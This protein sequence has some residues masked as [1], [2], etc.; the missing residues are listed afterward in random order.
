MRRRLALLL[1]LFA[2][3]CGGGGTFT[4]VSQPPAGAVAGSAWSYRLQ[5]QNAAGA[6]SYALL[7]GPD[8]MEL[9]AAGVLSWTPG[10]ADLGSHGV[11]VEALDGNARAVQAWSLRVSQGVLL[12]TALSPR[13]HTLHSTNQDFIDHYS[14]HAPWGRAIAFHLGWRDSGASSGAVPG[15]AVA[16]MVAAQ[17]Y[18]FTPVIGFGWADGNGVPD[19]TS[20]SEPGNN[21]WSNAQTRN[22]FL[23]MV[24]SF[25]AQWRPR[26]L[27][28]GNETNSYYVTHTQAEWDAWMSEL[29]ACYA[30]VKAASPTTLVFTVFQYEKM[31]GLG[32]NAGWAF[33]E[34]LHL[35]DNLVA[36]THADFAG[37]TSYPY[38]EYGSLAAVPSDYYA[39]IGA[40]WLG[41]T[42]FTEIGWLAAPSFPYPG[43]EADQAA[44]VNFF[45]AGTE[46]LHLRYAAWLFLHDWD[47]QAMLPSIA[48][49]GLLNNDGSDARPADA[50]W[51]AAVLLRE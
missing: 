11:R 25:A 22:E 14:E 13:G 8:G 48:G 33:P 44:F 31:L 12:G 20:A 35:L 15:T 30:A 34:H 47:Q 45:F 39:A 5:V 18:G 40:H 32:A 43:G 24:S 38:L 17:T 2:A 10:F 9:S 7:S 3:A 23:F 6:V 21:S 46:A 41:G 36:G 37:F 29:A 27:F 42:A 19:L 1:T 28:L 51:R 50:A 49:I 26:W 16:G 4:I